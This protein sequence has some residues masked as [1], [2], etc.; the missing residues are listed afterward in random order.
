MTV[1]YES[2][3]TD[4]RMSWGKECPG[5]REIDMTRRGGGGE[6][7]AREEREMRK[8]SMALE[9]FP[10]LVISWPAPSAPPPFTP[11]DVDFL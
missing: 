5:K 4:R 8:A 11:D 1:P 2:N 10:N 6:G 7:E 9:T 3:V